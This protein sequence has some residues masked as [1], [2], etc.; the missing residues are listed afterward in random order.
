VS[1]DPIGRRTEEALGRSGLA[2]LRPAYRKLLLRLK[3]SDPAAFEEATRRYRDDLEPAIES[4]SR[5]PVTA[6]LEYGVWLAGR[7]AEG[8]P[9]AIDATGRARD[10]DP[11]ETSGAGDM[12]LFL[13]E[14]DRA[15]V[16]LLAVPGEPSDPQRETAALLTG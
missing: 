14:D 8:R 4:G 6:W 10:F 2:D 13:P 9:V 3:E 7:F 11:E 16:T 15:P 12:I 1:E 5:D